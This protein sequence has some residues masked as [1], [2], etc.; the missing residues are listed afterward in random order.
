LRSVALDRYLATVGFGP[1]HAAEIS[2]EVDKLEREHLDVY[3]ARVLAQQGNRAHRS[4]IRAYLAT[5][6]RR[7]S[8]HKPRSTSVS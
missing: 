5:A 1:A 8:K 4:T 7:R 2:R 3:L 6:R